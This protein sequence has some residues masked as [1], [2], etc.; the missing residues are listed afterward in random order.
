MAAPT[1]EY[2]SRF[3]DP[4]PGFVT[5]PAVDPPTSAC[6]TVAGEACGDPVRYSAATPATWGAAID[7]PLIVAVAVSEECPADLML[8]PGANRS[9]HVPKFEKDERASV[10]VV[11]P[12]VSASGVRPGE[13]LH[14]FAFALPAA[15]EYVT[16]SAI[17]VF[18]AWSSAEDGEPPRLMFATAGVPAAWLFVTQSIPAM[19][20]EVV[21]LPLQSSTRTPTRRA[22]LA[23][24]YVAPPTVPAT[25]VP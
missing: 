3:G 24:P 22:L 13:S 14:A 17:E 7:V 20:P 21:P 9:R 2:S 11:A 18:T 8:D 15:S 25:C 16:P 6:A 1:S 5:L 23:T 4:V 12:T 10:D 19:T